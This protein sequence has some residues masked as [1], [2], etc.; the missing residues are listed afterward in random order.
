ML[1]RGKIC[2]PQEHKINTEEQIK[3]VSQHTE[4]IKSNMLEQKSTNTRRQA[5]DSGVRARSQPQ[6]GSVEVLWHD[7]GDEWCDDDMNERST[8]SQWYSHNTEHENAVGD[9][10]IEEPDAHEQR[11]QQDQ[12]V[13]TRV[14]CQKSDNTPLRYHADD[15]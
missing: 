7:F 2:P 11:W 9:D 14:P 8:N 13:I 15:P 1:T 3:H 6:G 5:P 10:E 12:R 4:R